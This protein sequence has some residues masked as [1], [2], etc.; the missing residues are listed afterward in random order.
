MEPGSV[1]A[2]YRVISLLGSG[3]MGQVWLVENPALG[4]R[5]AMKIISPDPADPSFAE[6]FRNEARTSAALD[7]RGIVT[8]YAFGVEEDRPWFTMTYLDG[9]DLTGAGPMPADEVVTIVAR[10]AD[11]LAHAHSQRVIHRDIKPG[12]IVVARDAQGGISRVT[13][14]DFGIARLVDGHRLT[15]TNLFVG[16]LAYAAPE[17]LTGDS[18]TPA[19]DQY[20]LAC[21]AFQLLTGRQPYPGSTPMALIAGHVNSPIPRLADL[22][23]S[24]AH[25]DPVFGR[26]LAKRP[27][28]RFAS[29]PEFAEALRA[30]V[31]THARNA[32][33]VPVNPQ[34]VSPPPVSHRP[35]QQP[36]PVPPRSL[37]PQGVP[38]QVGP[39]PNQPFNPHTPAP[40][41]GGG[42]PAQSPPQS[43]TGPTPSSRKWWWIGG[44]AAVV[45]LVA[46]AATVIALVS[47]GD[48]APST[49]IAGPA[50]P[51]SSDSASPD[52]TPPTPTAVPGAGEFASIAS[53]GD[54]TC[55][56]RSRQLWCWGGNEKGTV[57]DG[58]TINR[59]T[60][61][62]IT[63][64]DDVSSVSM[65]GLG[66]ACAVA[67]G[68]LYCWGSRIGR[69]DQKVTTPTR[70]AGLSDVTAVSVGLTI[71]AIGSGDL[72][73]WGNNVSGQ[74]GNG[75]TGVVAEPT[76]VA[77]LENVTA[78]S[79]GHTTTCAIASDGLYCWGNNDKGQIGDGTTTARLTPT[80]VR[81]SNPTAVST[82]LSTTCAVA[83]G[84]A[85]D[86]GT[87]WCWGDNSL[88]QIGDGTDVGRRT[89]TAIDVRGATQ[90]S[91][92]GF[93]ACAAAD[94][95]AIC[96][97]SRSSRPDHVPDPVTGL[98]EVARV[99]ASP[100]GACA[101]ADG[102]MYCWGL[103]GKGQ[104]GDGTTGF[105][106]EPRP[107]RFPG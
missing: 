50:G 74:A 62:R 43:P 41:F 89:P 8:V 38:T 24:W 6:R 71:C 58:T 52:T 12:N 35:P 21:T 66:T 105:G 51:G 68:D 84:P 60:P 31:A 97:G 25:L 3:G 34:P 100:A 102:E 76:R 36:T 53:T 103:N 73:C 48:D 45:V 77:G 32:R 20:A 39:P 1:F 14:L 18:A 57:G 30:A 106:T 55:A 107:V 91:T 81:L 67:S 101:V 11:A 23:P 86:P 26:A 59:S 92:A 83:D 15:A 5:E 78:V 104:L 40:A 79:N 63:G 88:G 96:W 47:S 64:I 46:L 42:F 70:V 90:V 95:A 2:G 61:V 94:G 69:P 28:D 75:S 33:T 65:G 85:G 27:Q 13:V 93:G 99:A 49:P 44:A 7:H 54:T 82:T 22:D 37:P 17:L 19:S 98:R 87:V 4:R 56:V 72:Y 80:K 29:C 16:T 9:H 10:T